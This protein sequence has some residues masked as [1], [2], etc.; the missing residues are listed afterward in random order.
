MDL[1]YARLSLWGKQLD[2]AWYSFRAQ[3]HGLRQFAVAGK[4]P[5]LPN[6]AV[7]AYRR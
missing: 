7:D 3:N 6:A 2:G 1:L 5:S 4:I